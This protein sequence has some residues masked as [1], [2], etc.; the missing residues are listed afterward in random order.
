MPLMYLFGACIFFILMVYLYLVWRHQEKQNLINV[1]SYIILG[2]AFFIILHVI[3][4]MVFPINVQEV[5]YPIRVL[6]ENHEVRRG[7][8]VKLLVEMKKYVDL[9]SEVYPTILCEDGWY[10]TFQSRYSNVPMG[11]QKLILDGVYQIPFN[12]PVGVVCKTRATDVFKLNIF[13]E[14]RFI[15]ESE[16]FTIIE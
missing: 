10:S 12:A 4:L 8:T 6:N 14:V 11:E 13:R 1:M 7:E 9:P 15:H 3:G 16:P 5:K 2:V